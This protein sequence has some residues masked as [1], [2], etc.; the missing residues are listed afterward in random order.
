MNRIL[1]FTLYLFY[2][3]GFSQQIK[4][5]KT[6]HVFVALC[7]NIN[8]GIVPVPSK[9]GNGQ[10]IKGNLYWSALY[11]VKTHFKNSKDWTFISSEKNTGHPILERILFKHKRSNTYLLADAYDGKYIKQTIKD[12]LEASAGRNPVNIAHKN[13]TLSFG[14]ASQLQAYIGHNG[15]MEFNVQGNFSSLNND[16]RDAIILACISKDYFKSYLEQTKVNPLVWSTGLMAPEAYTLKWAIDGWILNETDAQ[17][18]ERAAKAYNQ[19]Q[20]CG[21][22]GARGLLVTGY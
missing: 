18:R 20:K 14:G 22:K 2:A 6:I 17:I 5:V 11:G 9:L 16:K 3:T 21:L 1:F 19:Y 12:F 10:D 4:P 8:Q 13:S 7:D 15:L